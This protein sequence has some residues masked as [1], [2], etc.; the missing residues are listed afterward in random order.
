MLLFLEVSGELVV[1]VLERMDWLLLVWEV[2][3]LDELAVWLLLLIWEVLVLDELAVGL[4]LIWEEV[5][6]ELAV[7]LLLLFEEALEE[8]VDW[9]MEDEEDLDEP[10]VLVLD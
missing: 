9:V 5:L 2:L 7:G 6:D 3:V 8:L 4:L 1:W 10:V